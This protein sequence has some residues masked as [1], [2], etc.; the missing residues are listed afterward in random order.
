MDGRD[1]DHDQQN[2]MYD[3]I[4]SGNEEN[5]E[6]DDGSQY[7]NP[8]GEGI[9]EEQPRDEGEPADND[10]GE[11]IFVHLTD[12]GELLI[13]PLV[14]IRCIDLFVYINES[15]FLLALRIE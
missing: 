13:S 2:V 1:R 15:F 14:F 11:E 3:M 10:D 8:S 6:V 12:S 5:E 7:L 9:E 4:R